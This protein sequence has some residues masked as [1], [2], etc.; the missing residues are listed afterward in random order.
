MRELVGLMLDVGTHEIS[1]YAQYPDFNK[2]SAATR[3]N[4]DWAKYLDRHGSGMHYDKKCGH[5]DEGDTPYGHQRCCI[6]V[7]ADFAAEALLLFP[8]TVSEC[9]DTHFEDFYNNKAHAHEQ[10]ELVDEK[11]LTGLAARR[12]LMV[13]LGQDVTVLDAKITKALDPTDDTEA[14]VKVNPSK[15]WADASVKKGITVKKVAVI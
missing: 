3:K 8:K 6:A 9:S 12:S 14:G 2:I 10:A 4:M 7:P 5:Q 1:G 13:S 11:T 15:T